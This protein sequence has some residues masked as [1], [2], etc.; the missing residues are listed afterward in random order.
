[1]IGNRHFASRHF[2]SVFPTDTGGGDGVIYAVGAL[3]MRRVIQLNY[4]I[5]ATGTLAAGKAR[6]LYL[7]FAAVGTVAYEDAMTIA[8]AFSMAATGALTFSKNT[9]FGGGGIRRAYWAIKA[10]LSRML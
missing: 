9:I 7:A 4:Q 2:Q 6:E 8:R 10:R 1:M 5:L 3:T